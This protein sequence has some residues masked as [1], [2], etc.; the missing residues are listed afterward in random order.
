MLNGAAKFHGA[1]LNKSLLTG[2]DLLQNLIYVLLRFRQHPYAVS[3]DIEGMFLQV[4]VLPSDQPSLRFQWRE[5]PTTSAVVVYQYTRHI[6]G[7]KDSPT[8]ANYALQRTARDNAK[9]YPEAAKAVL[10][11]FYMDDYLDSVEYPEKAINRSKELVHLLHLGGFKLTKFVSNVQNLA[12]RI[13]GSPQSTEPKVIVSCQED[14]SH[15]LGLKWDH[16]NDTL[17]VSRGTSCAITK[18]LTQRLV[19]S[20]VSKVFD[21]I[22]LVAPFTVGARLLLKDIWRI[23]GQQWDDELPQDMVQRFLVWSADLPKLE[24]IKIPRSYFSGPFDNTELHMFGDSSQDIFSAVAFLRARVTTPTGKIKTE[25]AFVLGKARVAPMKVITVPKLELQAALLAARLQ[26]EIIQALTVTVNH[27][28]MWTDST[29][30]LQWINSNEKQPIFVANRVCEILEYTSVDQWNHVATKDNP[31]DAGTRGMSAEVLQLSSWVNGPHFLSN[32]SFTF[33]PNNDVINNI[34]LGVNQAVIIEDTVSLATSVKKQTTPVPSLFPFDKFSSYQKYLRIAAY[35]LRL[36]PKHAGYRNPDGSITDPTELD[37]A[38]R[39]LQY[40]VKG[41]SFEAERKDLIDNKFVKR[42][43]RIAPH[44]PFISPNG[45]I[46]SSGRL[47]RLIEVGFN[48]KHPIILDARHPFVKL[49]LE[50]THV[51][52]YHQGVE[53]LRSIVQE[54]YTVLKLRSS[55]RSIKAHCLRCREFQAVTMQP[56]MSDLPKE[57]LAYQSPPFTNTGVDY[58]GSFY[59]TVRR[60]TEKRWG[61][62]FTCLTT[63]AVHVEIVTSMDTSSCVMGVERFVSRRGT[64]AMIWSDNGTNFIGAEKELRESIEKWNVVNIAAELAHKG[65]KWKFNPPSAPHQGGIWERLV[66]SFKRVLYTILGT[67]RLTDEVLHTTFCLVENA[68]NSRPLTPVSADPCDLNAITPNHFLLGEH[69]T[70]IPSVVGNNEF[71]HRKRYARAQSYA[72]AIWS[73]WIK[74]YVPTLNRRS[75]WQTPAEQHLKTGDLVWIAEET[76]PRGYYPI[77]RIVELRYGSD[78]VARSAVLRT[79]TGSLVRPLVKL[80]PVF[81]T[82]SSGPEDV[83]K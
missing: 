42:S 2:P 1:S 49:F 51:K 76:N 6:F 33:V 39:H 34:K 9:F 19:L 16:T 61:F 81:P 11:N 14:S 37:E 55:L 31:A 10:E 46:R 27:V 5:D 57:R 73:R 64:P 41:E 23:T 62:L 53:Y 66:R 13:D 56:I 83:T 18:S 75:K 45:L 38:E 47:K 8:C 26:N 80:V 78:S 25:L 70:G 72:N 4:G 69:S 79:S 65:I 63:R 50:H 15:V 68:L 7:A 32:S 77:A 59:V 17:V 44:S 28:F 74:E 22:G 35:V 58:F 21:P 36:L 60:T 40:L 20:L 54:H 43:S 67:R 71:D 24:N 52:H 48:V 82:S 29:T 30:V 12:D 3:A